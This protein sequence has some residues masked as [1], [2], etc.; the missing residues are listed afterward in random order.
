MIWLGRAATTLAGLGLVMSVG[1]K[2]PGA[3]PTQNTAIADSADQV[4]IRM[5]TNMIEDGVRTGHVTADTAYVYQTAQQMDLR[6]LRVTFFENGKQTSVLTAQQ[7][8]YNITTGSLDARGDVRVVST[9]G[10]K[11]STPHLIYDRSTLQIRGDTTFLYESPTERIT[12][13]AFTSDFEFRNVTIHQP[14]G[15]QRGPGIPVPGV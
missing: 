15:R 7:G 4:M 8:M 2:D 3:R 1:C 6:N 9:D 13:N 11:L 5:S 10:R 12:G 14:K